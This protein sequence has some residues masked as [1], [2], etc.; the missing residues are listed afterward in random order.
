M[1][2]RF[3][4]DDFLLSTETAG[5]LF[6]EVAARLPIVDLHNHLSA[7][8]IA[9]NR[10]FADLTELWL[11]DDHYKWR[12]MRLAGVDERLVT[13]D[14]DPWERFSAWAATVPRLIRNPLYL[15]THLELRRVFG[16]ELAL[17]PTTAREIWDEANR[18]LPLLPARMLLSRFDVA[19]LAT[20]DDPVD[21]LAAHR[22]L[23]TETGAPAVIPTYRPDAAH[24][25]LGD[26]AAWNAWADRL[27]EVSGTPV[28]DLESLLAAL[29]RCD[30]RFAELGRRASDHG[31]SRLPDTPRD[32]AVADEAIRCARRG[33]AVAAA[34]ADAVAPRGR[35]SRRAT[36]VRVRRRAPA[37]P[38]RAP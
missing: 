7:S 38:R 28:E 21:D 9:D 3:L 12:A 8:D 5:R 4:G 19:A 16:I 34:E 32:P 26:L 10:V 20:T 13:G 35:R 22:A 25:L 37:P 15:W 18:Q 1:N 6:H 27:E 17:D 30:E 31:L 24:R 14:A 2:D 36:R 23:R 11:E 29:T 33:D